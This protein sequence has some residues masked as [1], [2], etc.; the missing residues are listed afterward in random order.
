M[1]GGRKKEHI[2]DL[3]RWAEKADLKKLRKAVEKDPILVTKFDPQGYT[4]LHYAAAA[5]ST[6]C[7]ELLIMNGAKVNDCI[8]FGEPTALHAALEAKKEETALLLL[9]KGA[10]PELAHLGHTGFQLAADMG[11][12]FELEFRETAKKNQSRVA[13]PAAPS[14]PTSTLSQAPKQVAAPAGGV[15]SP[16]NNKVPFTNPALKK[17]QSRPME[18]KALSP[19]DAAMV[20]KDLLGMSGVDFMSGSQKGMGDDGRSNPTQ[21]QQ[22]KMAERKVALEKRMHKCDAITRAIEGYEEITDMHSPEIRNA[23]LALG[24]S[25]TSLSSASVPATRPPP[26]SV[27]RNPIVKKTPPSTPTGALTPTGATTPKSPLA[28][29]APAAAAKPAAA[30]AAQKAA[31]PP[32]VSVPGKAPT[33]DEAARAIIQHFKSWFDPSIGRVS[34][35]A[36]Y[37]VVE[38][39]AAAGAAAANAGAVSPTRAPQ[40][41]FV[42]SPVHAA[43]VSPTQQST[44]LVALTDVLLQWVRHICGFPIISKDFDIKILRDKAIHNYVEEFRTYHAQLAAQVELQQEMLGDS[45]ADTRANVEILRD[46]VVNL[47]DQYF[48]V[49]LRH[50]DPANLL[51]A[52]MQIIGA[53]YYTFQSMFSSESL[54]VVAST[55]DFVNSILNLGKEDCTEELAADCCMKLSGTV[56][57]LV[58]RTPSAETSKL[59]SFH[60]GMVSLT[61]RALLIDSKRGAPKRNEYNATIGTHL[62]KMKELVRNAARTHRGDQLSVSDESKIFEMSSTYMANSLAFY[63]TVLKTPESKEVIEALEKVVPL[64][65]KFASL[66]FRSREV[67][68]NSWIEVLQAAFDMTEGVCHFCD[69]TVFSFDDPDSIFDTSILISKQYLLQ[70]LLSIVSLAA[71]NPL[72]PRHHISMSLRALSI[73]L[74]SIL[75]VFY[76]SA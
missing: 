15:D 1:I 33:P 51:L 70:V 75:D 24:F 25:A 3:C 59:L 32:P 34:L 27:K 73:H 76:L 17:Q 30:V 63:K 43:V 67:T 49:A 46:R 55:K 72:I 37:P 58:F 14:A 21:Q 18:V 22:A 66:A 13:K 10:N 16:R 28:S 38:A 7:V 23:V 45:Y 6:E 8:R 54:A 50:E 44:T 20:A 47:I 39:P 42:N 4:P 2:N 61:T 36:W 31:R 53:S 74:I 5:G 60:V 56:N 48:T 26:V 71:E 40:T 68:L 12:R 29:A 35:P 65:R 19:A 69:D 9:K 11:K 41:D 52:Y 62:S 57:S 64:V